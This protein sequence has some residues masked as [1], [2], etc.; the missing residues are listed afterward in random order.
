LLP[1]FNAPGFCVLHFGSGHEDEWGDYDDYLENMSKPLGYV[2]YDRYPFSKWFG[3]YM[4]TKHHFRVMQEGAKVAKKLDMPF[5][6]TGQTY[7]EGFEDA[8]RP[9]DGQDMLWQANLFL[10]FGVRKVYWYTYWRFSTRKS[11]TSVPTAVMDDYGERMI[12]DEVQYANAY[13]QKLATYVY[14]Y[15]YAASQLLTK[16]GVINDACA[17]MICE[18]LGLFAEYS[19]DAPVLVNKL[20]KGENAAYMVMNT[21]DPAEKLVNRVALKFNAPCSSLVVLLG[22]E[23]VEVPV[24]NGAVSFTLSPGEAVW[25][26]EIK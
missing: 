26:L 25:I 16:D 14:E 6:I 3:E 19:V 2:H 10:G 4:L 7:S 12:Y 21:R 17:D 13:M 24:E 22:G 11:L 15:D 5:W 8:T 18:D 9:V 23:K 20:V 1:Y